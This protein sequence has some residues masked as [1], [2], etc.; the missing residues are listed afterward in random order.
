ML[1]TLEEGHSLRSSQVLT[2]SGQTDTV[3]QDAG[4]RVIGE[5]ALW[6]GGRRCRRMQPLLPVPCCYQ[7]HGQASAAPVGP[8]WGH[9]FS[10]GGLFDWDSHLRAPT[11]TVGTKSHG[12]KGM[13]EICKV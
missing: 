6:G 8:M 5:Q 1:G 11:H 13:I 4:C 3:T 2:A 7:G 12:N 9:L 10:S